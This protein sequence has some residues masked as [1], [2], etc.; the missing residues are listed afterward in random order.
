[1]TGGTIDDPLLS[2]YGRELLLKLEHLLRK[3]KEHGL[4]IA[5]AESLTAGGIANF[6]AS[7]SGA[8]EMLDRGYVVYNNE[9][10]AEMLGIDPALFD[11]C[12]AVSEPVAK[13]MVLGALERSNAHIAVSVTG[14]ASKDGNP[15]RGIQGGT[16]FIGLAVR[17]H[18]KAE[19]E[20]L[21]VTE[22]RFPTD[23]TECRA[24]TVKQAVSDLTHAMDV[25]IARH[26]ARS[27]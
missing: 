14:Y 3:S 2:H 6:L 15:A 12:D 13:R 24:A 5:T 8:S 4:K 22:H 16:V 20:L 9:A 1:M 26:A 25:V 21:R 11:T 7:L 27:R 18:I 17:G 10:K 19:P 23:R